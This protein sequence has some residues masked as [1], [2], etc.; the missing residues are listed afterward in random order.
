MPY[1]CTVTAGNITHRAGMMK[2][3]HDQLGLSVLVFDY[4]G[5]GRSEGSP[6]E[7]GVMLDARA[8]RDW[9]ADRVGIDKKE[10]ILIGES[11]GG[12]V[13]V[14]VAASDGAKALMLIS[15]FNRLPDVAAFHYPFLPIRLLMRAQFDSEDKIKNYHGPLVQYHGLGDTIVA[16][17]F[18]RRLFEAANEPKL[19][20]EQTGSDHNDSLP[21]KFFVEVRKFFKQYLYQA[22]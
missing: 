16:P 7:K 10:I 14:D 13:A 2:N 21:S 12:A 15:T 11:L 4:R 19:W 8:A 18:G 6:D 22:G 9:L 3:L 20:I 5:Y 17:E 1:L